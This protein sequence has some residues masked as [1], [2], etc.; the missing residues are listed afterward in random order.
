MLMGKVFAS[1]GHT[2]SSV[3]LLFYFLTPC[4]IQIMFLAMLRRKKV[5]RLRKVEDLNSIYQVELKTRAMLQ[6]LDSD[7][8]KKEKREK[9]TK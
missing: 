6:N 7:R 3:S 2:E 4:M 8:F 5:L 9:P 1:T